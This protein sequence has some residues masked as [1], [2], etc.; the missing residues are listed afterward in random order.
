LPGA[1][2]LPFSGGASRWISAAALVAEVTAL[3]SA[4]W[5]YESMTCVDRIEA[6]QAFQLV[7]TFNRYAEPGRLAL[8]VLAPKDAP[9]PSLSGVYPIAAW[10]EREAW[11]F[12]GLLFS[13]HPNLTWLLLPEDTDFR[14]LLKSF[15]GPPPSIY[16]DSIKP[17]I[18]EAGGRPH[19]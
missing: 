6:Q 11:E 5:F 1:E 16:D 4:G 12:Y 8:Q 19:V 13:G 14:P 10:N 3:R 2:E 18:P 9:V 7:Y 15:T 17:D